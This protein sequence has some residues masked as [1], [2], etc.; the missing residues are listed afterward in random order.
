VRHDSRWVTFTLVA[1]AQF[2]VVLD[3]AIIN[4][5]LPVIK[6]RLGFSDTSVQWAVTAYV[7][8]FGGFL[9]FGGRA[10]DLF[11]RRRVLLAGMT[12][13]TLFSLLIGLT[14]SPVMLVVLRGLQGASA[15]F[16]SPAALSTV[17]VTFADDE[18]QR[19]RALGFWS[20]TA[21]G[22]AAVGLLLGGVLTQYAG[23]RWNFF[24][25]VPVGLLTG[26]LIARL[27]P[28]HGPAGNGRHLDLPGAVLVT[29]GLMAAVLAFSQAP[30]WGWGDARTLGGL[31]AAVILIG[32]FTV[33]EQKTAQPLMPLSI[34]RVR[35][36]SGANGMMAAVYGGNLAMFFLLTLY[37]QGVEGY[38]AIGTGLAFLPFPVI[39]GFTST[40]MAGL[41]ARYG[42]RRFLILGPALIVASLTWTCFLPVHGD[43]V[44]H[45][46]PGLL[47]MP[48][49]YGM[50]FAPM[51]AAATTGVEPRLAGITS[52]LISASQQMGG[53]IGLAIVSGA[54]AAVTGALSGTVRAQAL[55]SGYDVGMGVAAGLTLVALLLAVTVIRVPHS[56]ADRGTPPGGAELARTAD[57]RDVGDGRAGAGPFGEP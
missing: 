21:T 26:I 49:G 47:I 22:G 9:L 7:L 51:Y 54:A 8:A 37:L 46:L 34:F 53:A 2:M 23:W 41:V 14:S 32:A 33:N 4:V 57:R 44:L 24:I 13:F 52:G 10:A 36:I 56:S 1:A 5:A 29:A 20:M 18:H 17:L 16:M 30:V 11:G 48:V 25:N 42:F 27:V 31:A 19:R 3:T 28:R 12:A 39:L 6:V 43:Y 15:A 35:N 55:T 50:S 38:S 40:R 45:V